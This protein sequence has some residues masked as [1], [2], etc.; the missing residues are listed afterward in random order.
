MKKIFI[1]ATLS[2]PLWAVSGIS[3]SLSACAAPAQK[4]E[5]KLWYDKPSE[6]WTD[7]LPLGN[8]AIGAM[9]YGGVA[10]ERICLNEETIWAG[11]PNRNAN[12]HAPE[13]LPK[14][15][16]LIYEGKN[17]EARDLA[18]SKIMSNTN[19]GMPY[20]PFGD[21]N[22]SFPGHIDYSGYYRELSIDSAYAVVNTRS[23]A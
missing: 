14:V 9:V 6:V 2:L 19:W 5:Y 11:Q 18:T 20:Q 16:Q 8:G 23:A 3:M 12:P 22:I 17:K 13:A 4:A 15:R 10:Q 1:L 21:L 7:A